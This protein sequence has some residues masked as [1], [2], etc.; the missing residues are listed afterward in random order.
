MPSLDLVSG[1]GGKVSI[2][3]NKTGGKYAAQRLLVV[4]WWTDLV[5]DYFGSGYSRLGFLASWPNDAGARF[6]G[7][8]S[9]RVLYELIF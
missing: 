6:Y 7:T 3:E 5:V 4:D 8:Q 2:S 9:Q 1:S